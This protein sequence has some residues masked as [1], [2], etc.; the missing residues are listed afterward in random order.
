VANFFDLKFRRLTPDLGSE[1]SIFCTLL[2][3]KALLG[4]FLILPLKQGHPRPT[5]TF[6]IVC[7][8]FKTLDNSKYI[9][10][11]MSQF[12]SVYP[13]ARVLCPSAPVCT[14]INSGNRHY[15]YMRATM[16]SIVLCRSVHDPLCYSSTPSW[17]SPVSALPRMLHPRAALEILNRHI[18]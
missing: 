15:H 16:A 10:G 14:L 13:I 4:L 18:H 11:F 2:H 12:G 9:P 5:N 3:S 6:F 7:I 8:V 17:S 1:G